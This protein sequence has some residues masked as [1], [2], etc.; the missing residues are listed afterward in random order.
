MIPLIVGQNEDDIGALGRRDGCVEF[1]HESYHQ[2]QQQQD[3]PH[4]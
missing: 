4:G 2:G 3:G 1:T